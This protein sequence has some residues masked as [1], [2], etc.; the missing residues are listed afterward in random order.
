MEY[1]VA[2]SE[3]VKQGVGA[4]GP[5]TL[6]KAKLNGNPQ[7][8]VGFE[9]VQ[10]GDKVTVTQT[11]NKGYTNLN[12]KKVAAEAAPSTGSI[13]APTVATTA[14]S[15]NND[16]RVVKLLVL[17]AEQMGIDKNQILDILEG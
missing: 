12:F 15:S 7:E 1:N 5:W 10:A 8:P 17:M 9:P 11:T 2:S 3:I 4:K 16:K 6:Y 13:A 14:E